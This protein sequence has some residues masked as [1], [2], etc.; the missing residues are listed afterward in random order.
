VGV[1]HV[2]DELA[3]PL[4]FLKSE[5]QNLR[6]PIEIVAQKLLHRINVFP[7]E[8]DQKPKLTQQIKH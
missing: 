5:H 2:H 8:Q 4:V 3:E 1:D 7:V 6:M